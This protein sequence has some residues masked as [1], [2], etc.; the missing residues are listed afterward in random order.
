MLTQLERK[1]LEKYRIAVDIY[2]RSIKSKDLK[3]YDDSLLYAQ[4][5]YGLSKQ[6]AYQY[7]RACKFLY[8]DT[9]TCM[10]DNKFT[11]TQLVELSQLWQPIVI[12]LYEMGKITHYMTCQEIRNIVKSE[13]PK[14]QKNTTL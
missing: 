9:C 2:N 11:I 5:T 1:N 3:G 12:K 8:F 13:K 4:E 6:I 14:Q 10:L 7:K